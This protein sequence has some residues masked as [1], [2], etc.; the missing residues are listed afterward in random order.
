MKKV[1]VSLFVALMGGLLT[2]P[3]VEAQSRRGGS[4]GGSTRVESGQRPGRGSHSG[5]GNSRPGNATRPGN[6]GNRPGGSNEYRPGNGGNRPGGS[7]EYRPGNG[8]GNRPGS[9][10]DYRPG[11]GGNRP[12]GGGDY[13][14]GNGG[15]RPGGGH[16][17][18]P[19]NGHPTPPPPAV[20]PSR[21][22]A[23]APRP[24][25]MAPP[26]RP[27][28]P[29]FGPWSRPVPPRAWRPSRRY[30][31][32][33]DILGM[34]F[35]LTI[36]SALD[37]LYSG[38]YSIDGYG[39]QEVYLRGVNEMGYYWDDATLY[40]TGGGLVRSQFYNSSVGYNT[41]RFY[42][43]YNRLSASFG[44]PVSQSN[45]GS[46]ITATWFGY[47]GDYIT[48]QYTLMNS[49]SGYRYFTILTCG[50]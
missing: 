12:G 18:R 7:N 39:S 48:L 4:R 26:T 2:V 38:G 33:P 5:Q 16:N 30:N 50:N 9:G 35:G 21:P 49:S 29:S 10:S 8:G 41:S 28:R 6:G 27:G 1:F 46:A 31:V 13:R 34:A 22:G 17:F 40:F 36:N 45:N 24:P 37:Y 3:V 43:V 15:N 47:Q 25:Y 19:G 20:R 32:V 23:M 11:N 44:V 42:G 14:P